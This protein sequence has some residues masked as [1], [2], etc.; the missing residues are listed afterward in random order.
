VVYLAEGDIDG[1]RQLLRERGEALRGYLRAAMIEAMRDQPS[2]LGGGAHDAGEESFAELTF[3]V[4]LAARAREIKEFRD[5]EATLKRIADGSFGYC[6]DCAT[7]I[8]L[9]RLR[10]YPTA[11]RCLPCQQRHE[12]KRS[13]GKDTS[14]SL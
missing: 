6:A 11:K 7:E 5:I 12:Q 14:P 8:G 13:A 4:D 3:G 9:A 1:F 10:I 2:A